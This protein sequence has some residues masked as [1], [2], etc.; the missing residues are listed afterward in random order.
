MTLTSCISRKSSRKDHGIELSFILR[1]Q[2]ER[3]NMQM[4]KNYLP[5]PER[6][7]HDSLYRPGIPF[8]HH[9][10][11]RTPLRHPFWVW[12]T[13]IQ[14]ALWELVINQVSASTP[15]AKGRIERAFRFFQDQ[16]IKGMCL[17]EIKDYESANRFLQEEVLPW[18]NQRYILF[19]ESTYRDIPRG[20]DLLL[21]FSIKHTRKARKDNTIKAMKEEYTSYSP[22]TAGSSYAGRW[23]EVCETLEGNL[24]LFLKGKAILY[25]VLDKQTHKQ[26]K[27]EVLSMRSVLAE[28]KPKKKYV[29]P[30]DHPWRRSWKKRNATFQTGN[31][32]W[33]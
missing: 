26:F 10:P 31:K 32:V 14:T 8:H 2:P 1:N 11:W 5:C 18:C 22:S 27:E 30:Q 4:L 28:K 3:S 15:Q 24:Q 12:D 16:L 17:R 6:A 21:V 7:F 33:L 19:V 29:L 23:I 25:Q 9:P 20:I 13:Q